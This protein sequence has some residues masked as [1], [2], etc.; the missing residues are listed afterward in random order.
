MFQKETPSSRRNIG[1]MGVEKQLGFP[2]RDFEFRVP[3]V[4]VIALL[5]YA[6]TS[7]DVRDVLATLRARQINS[8]SPV[9]EARNSLEATV[10]LAIC[11]SAAAAG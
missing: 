6:N 1:G 5:R 4:P 3:P 7:H 9:W 8:V 10:N 11:V 2:E